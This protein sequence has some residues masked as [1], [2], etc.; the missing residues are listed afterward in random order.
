MT[1]KFPFSKRRN[2]DCTVCKIAITEYTRDFICVEQLLF[3][4]YGTNA[5]A[6]YAGIMVNLFHDLHMFVLHNLQIHIPLIMR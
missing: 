5:Y 6:I 1:D 3:V 4:T 2:I